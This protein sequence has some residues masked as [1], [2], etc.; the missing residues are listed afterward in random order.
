MLYTITSD[1]TLRIFLPVLD[2]PQHVQL[3]ASLD[4]FSALPFSIASQVTSSHIFSLSRGVMSDALKAALEITGGDD[5]DARSMRVRDIR[6]ESWDLFLRVLGDGSLVVQAVA[7]SIFSFRLV[8]TADHDDAPSEHRPSTPDSAETVHTASVPTFL[9]QN[10]ASTPLHS[11]KSARAK[12]GDSSDVS[13]FA[14]IRAG[15]AA[16][17][18]CSAR[19][20]QTSCRGRGSTESGQLQWRSAYRSIREDTGRR[21]TGC[22][23]GR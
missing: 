20:P 11:A 17:L 13:A 9:H 7:V 19:W 2:S 5:E 6:A 1:A 4:V 8:E 22:D 14:F 3:H 16:I 18:R 10:S 21:R 12:D 15:A 23:Q